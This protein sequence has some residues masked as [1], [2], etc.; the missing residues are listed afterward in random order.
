MV[1]RADKK[2]IYY[3]ISQGFDIPEIFDMQED[4]T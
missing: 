3:K 2:T 4:F 1:T